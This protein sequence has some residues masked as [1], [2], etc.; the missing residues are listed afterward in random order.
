MTHKS[1]EPVILDYDGLMNQKLP[2]VLSTLTVLLLLSVTDSAG[3]SISFYPGESFMERAGVFE[4]DEGMVFNSSIFP[5]GGEGDRLTLILS[6]QVE[7]RNLVFI[8]QHELL[9]S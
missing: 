6:T 7:N 8:K 1:H 5:F 3:A 4:C 2:G 9:T